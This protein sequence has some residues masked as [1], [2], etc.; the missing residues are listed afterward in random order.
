MSAKRTRNQR[1]NS[2]D[3]PKDSATSEAEANR[4][5]GRLSVCFYCLEPLARP[6][7]QSPPPWFHQNGVPYGECAQA[8]REKHDR[9]AA[10]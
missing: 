5:G 8:L 9:K 7:L 10:H 1:T 6:T 2:G 3:L 4:E